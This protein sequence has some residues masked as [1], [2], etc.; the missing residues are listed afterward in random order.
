MKTT[1]KDYKLVINTL[2]L[3]KFCLQFSYI[4][5][6]IFGVFFIVTVFSAYEIFI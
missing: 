3:Y 4:E 2:L 5:I 1:L 6:N